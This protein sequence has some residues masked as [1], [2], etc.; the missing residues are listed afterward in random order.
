MAELVYLSCALASSLCAILLVRSYRA[1]RTKL[2][3]WSSLCFA[4]LALNNALLFVDLAIA[5]GLDLSLYRSLVALAALLLLLF[6]L[7]WHVH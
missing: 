6:G 4:G 3:L 1:S 2:L 5:P 7:I